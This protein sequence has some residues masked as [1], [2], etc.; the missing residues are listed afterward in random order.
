MKPTHSRRARAGV[1]PR[2]VAE[3]VF[4]AIVGGQEVLREESQPPV[5]AE[6]GATL[7]PGRSQNK[8]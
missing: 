1:S 6:V 3:L 7:V 2:R 5:R 8:L 4:W